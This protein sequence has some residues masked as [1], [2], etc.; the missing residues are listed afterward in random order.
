MDDAVPEV[1]MGVLTLDHIINLIPSI[2]VPTNTS[3]KQ[4]GPTNSHPHYWWEQRAQLQA[5]LSNV[6]QCFCKLHLIGYWLR[7]CEGLLRSGE[8][9]SYY[10]RFSQHG[11]S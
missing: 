1:A 9:L 4:H 2:S 6:L 11:E 8:A 10:T 3:P 5:K 7:G